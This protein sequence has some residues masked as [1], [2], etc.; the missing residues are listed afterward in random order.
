MILTSC[1]KPPI[2][3]PETPTKISHPTLNISSPLSEGV[4]NQYDIWQF[5]KQKPL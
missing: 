1:S 2:P 4:I 3:V 5:L